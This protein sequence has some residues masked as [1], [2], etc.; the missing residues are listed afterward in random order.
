LWD[1]HSVGFVF[2]PNLVGQEN[3]LFLLPE[4]FKLGED[5][6]W[7]PVPE[8]KVPPATNLRNA[9][10]P[11]NPRSEMTYLTPKEPDCHWQ[12][13]EGA[14]NKPG[15]TAGPFTAELGD[16]STATYYW[17]RF[18]D[19]PAIIQANFP[20]TVREAMQSRV[21]LIHENWSIED[22]YIAPLKNGVV[23]TV[24]PGALV[25]PPSGLEVG[26]VPI[27]TR[28]EKSLKKIRVFVLAGQS[29]MQG[30][31]KIEA[32]QRET[33]SLNHVIQNDTSG[34]WSEIGEM[35]DW[36][37]LD[38]AW[39]FYQQN[40]NT[41][42]TRV[43][44]GQGAFPD[45]IGP[46][47]MFAHKL[48]GYFDDPILIIKTAWGGRNLAVD[49]RPPS[50]GG[51]TGK[52][53]SQMIETVHEVTQNLATEFPEISV[54]SFEISGFAWFQ[55]W[56]DGASDE[57]S[58]EYQSNLQHLVNDVR[59]EFGNPDL[60]FVVATSGHGGIELSGDLWV[61]SMQEVVSVAQANVGC[62]Y[63]RYG[64]RVGLVDTKPL[65]LEATASPDDA[66]HHF[67]N[68]ALTFLNIG[69]SLGDEMIRAINDSSYCHQCNVRVSKIVSIGNR[70]WNDLNRDGLNSP[71]EP[72]IP[73][74]S[75]VLWADSD[76]DDIPDW[77]GFRGVEV[78]DDEGYYQFRGLAPGNY[79]VF[80]WQVNNWGVGEPLAGFVSTN[81]YVADA[82][83]D[84]DND[85]N[86]SG[87][88]FND[89]MSGIVTLSVGE[90]PGG[91]DNNTVDFGF[92]RGP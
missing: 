17:Y 74:V 22:D 30:Y 67:H 48:D 3:G 28:Q 27:V 29:N 72:G 18:V 19:Q 62:N 39:L 37:S 2:D 11:I 55:G 59:S 68:N 66:I 83:N 61:R 69:K 14:W 89:I 8:T 16:G 15:P 86:G 20:E 73:G 25:K 26:F 56:N 76:G 6:R 52:F 31:G 57:F 42:K 40:E 36:T 23:A 50:A 38:N 21:E 4:Y 79:I 53:Y 80:V 47:L 5:N 7:Q 1:D 88:T 65:Y 91:S 87:Q 54:N 82:N 46:E 49:F 85:N 33:N 43:T 10:L 35:G 63:T 60:P 84:V 13:L 41:L 32:G 78:T 58:K 71:D 34:Q 24:D 64:G 51:E 77:Q 70:V 81:A 75:V 92:Y 44:V 45:L 9:T 90:E 12:D